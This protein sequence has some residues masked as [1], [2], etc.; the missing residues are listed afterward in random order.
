MGKRLAESR[1]R[2]VSLGENENLNEVMIYKL[3]LY[4]VIKYLNLV[5]LRK[6]FEGDTCFH[7]STY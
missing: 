3:K 4:W 5:I 6:L 7:Q 2:R 1:F